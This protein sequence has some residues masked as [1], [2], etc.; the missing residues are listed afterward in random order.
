MLC[1]YVGNTK[2][3]NQIPPNLSNYL[4][5]KKTQLSPGKKLKLY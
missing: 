3:K 4:V 1:F 2:L 5:N